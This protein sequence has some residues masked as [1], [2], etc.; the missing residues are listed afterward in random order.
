MDS[1]RHI[2]SPPDPVPIPKTLLD[3]AVSCPNNHSCLSAKTRKVCKVIDSSGATVFVKGETCQCPYRLSFGVSHKLCTCPVRGELHRRYGNL[4]AGTVD[5][6]APPPLSC[7]SCAR[8][9]SS[10]ASA[11]ATP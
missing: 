7:D 11:T 1:D 4:T 9:G 3:K 5:T 10:N 6:D 8:H 2:L